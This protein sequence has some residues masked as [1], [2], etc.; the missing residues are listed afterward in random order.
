MPIAINGTN[1]VYFPIPKLACT[2]VKIALLRHN[3]PE[4][5]KTLLLYLPD[6]TFA[7]RV[8][9]A[10]RTRSIHHVYP[11]AEWQP[12]WHLEKL[13]KQQ[14][15]CLV[16]DPLQRFLSA[17][18]NRVVFHDD[19][20]RRNADDARQAGLDPRPDLETFADRLEDYCRVSPSIRHHTKPMWR[21]LGPLPWAY[22]RIFSLRQIPELE[23]FCA[24]AGAMIQIPHEQTGGPKCR[25]ED[26]PSKARRKL[27]RYYAL[28]YR[29]YGKHFD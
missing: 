22:T 13:R 27:E 20:A 17:Y 1:L 4:T 25:V 11:S 10:G 29:L 3:Q 6:G 9:H 21:Y 2:S 8:H 28:D 16:R 19:I 24:D 5:A 15:V 23:A 7:P 12:R 26:L 14:W 18:G